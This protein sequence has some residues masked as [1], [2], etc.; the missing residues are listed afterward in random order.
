MIFSLLNILFNQ[1]D[2]HRG[3]GYVM[4]SLV[5]F[6][7]C[8]L[9]CRSFSIC[10]NIFCVLRQIFYVFIMFYVQVCVLFPLGEDKV[11]VELIF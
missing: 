4:P 7:L 8:K 5:D 11:T 10:L 2:V 9:T 3:L 6:V 1:L